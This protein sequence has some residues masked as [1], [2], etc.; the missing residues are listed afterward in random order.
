MDA[1]RHH[2]A[3]RLR[4]T[5]RSSV[6]DTERNVAAGRDTSRARP[7]LRGGSSLR[8]T[9][10][11]SPATRESMSSPSRQPAAAVSVA[12]LHVSSRHRAAQTTW[13]GD[14][15]L[16]QQGDTQLAAATAARI[17]V[18]SASIRHDV[19]SAFATRRR[20]NAELRQADEQLGIRHPGQT[21]TLPT[22]IS[23]FHR[24]HRLSGRQLTGVRAPRARWQPLQAHPEDESRTSR[25]ARL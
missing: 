10:H 14:A 15:H 20:A 2:A 11:A 19:A 12:R 4:P 5:T 24:H 3:P 9:A 6:R 17:G 7:P 25:E 16:L 23:G 8:S 18:L 1:D 13:V 22:A 21:V